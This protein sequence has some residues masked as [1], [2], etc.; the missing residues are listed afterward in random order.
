MQILSGVT[1]KKQAERKTLTSLPF[2]RPSFLPSFPPVC[3]PL[4]PMLYLKST[5]RSTPWIFPYLRVVYPKQLVR[6]ANCD[7]I[8][9]KIVNQSMSVS[10]LLNLKK[11]SKELFY[12]SYYIC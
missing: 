3:F 10:L 1:H 2:L 8:P 12:L 6:K 7:V 9:F 11:R 5:S 4:L